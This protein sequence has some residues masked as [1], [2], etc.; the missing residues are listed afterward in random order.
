M[1]REAFEIQMS[2]MEEEEEQQRDEEHC[3]E[4]R[5]QPQQKL[6]QDLSAGTGR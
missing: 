6:P 1:I 5:N 2:R 3:K 4:H